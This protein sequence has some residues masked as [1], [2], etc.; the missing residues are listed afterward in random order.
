VVNNWRA[1]VLENSDYVKIMDSRCC[2][3]TNLMVQNAYGYNAISSIVGLTPQVPY[4][5]SSRFVIDVP[6]GL[7]ITSTAYEYDA[8]G[9]MLGWHVHNV[10]S[11]YA[12]RDN[13][14]KL[15]EMISGIG[16]NSAGDKY[17][18]NLIPVD[19]L[20]SYRVYYN[21]VNSF[22]IPSDWTDVTGSDSYAIYNGV[23]ERSD[24][25]LDGQFLVRTEAR[26]LAYDLQATMAD[27]DLRF[28]LSHVRT[29]NGIP[30]NARLDVPLGKIDVFLNGKSLIR[31]LDYF[32]R[33]PE[34]TIVN[35]EYLDDPLN[36]LQKIHVRH[37]GYCDQTLQ[38]E[39]PA[40]MGF[41]VHGVLSKN[42]KFDIRDDKVLR[43][44][45]DGALYSRSE[46]VYSERSNAVSTFDARNG[47]P[48]V[49]D[50]IVV[51]LRWLTTE[52]TFVVRARSQAIDTVVSDY[53]TV[54]IPESVTTVPS[55]ITSRY[56][57]FSPFLCK[58]IYDLVSSVFDEST[59][60]G[61]YQ[62]SDIPALCA[63]YLFLLSSDPTQQLQTV[64][65]NYVVIHPHNLNTVID[66]DIYAY[67]FLEKVVK[68]YMND[69]VN[70]S[71]F[72]RL[73]SI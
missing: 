60:Q 29:I 41:I 73:K 42:T 39:K 40:D 66:V 68:V 44:V 31:D 45:V 37:S 14:T 25:E 58:I 21:P 33:F 26:F 4:S 72:L 50:D 23:L 61:S 24:G 17:A 57:I 48:Y 43:I 27:G 56:A 70:L 1:E 53:L 7:Q 11:T 54:K 64:D 5:F 20:Q 51:P 38:L 3:V 2:D 30:T 19:V 10:G 36:K 18:V 62:L 34:V 32:V 12:C 22:G 8:N 35:K 28:N 63:D 55:A 9:I 49:I 52:P 71:P 46:L 69:L 47:Q 15:V 16:G 59:I 65:S 13:R 67:R 6:Y